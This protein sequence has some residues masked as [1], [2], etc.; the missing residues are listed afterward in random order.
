M[1]DEGTFAEGF[2][3][4]YKLVRGKNVGMPGT[5][6]RPGTPGNTTPFLQGLEA[7]IR[8]AGGTLTK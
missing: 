7:G 8:A 6:G 5:P 4:G 3:V 1:I 2:E